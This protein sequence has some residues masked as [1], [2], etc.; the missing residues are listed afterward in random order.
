MALNKQVYDDIPHVARQRRKK[1]AYPHPYKASHPH[2]YWFIDGRQMDFALDGVKWWSIIVLDGYSRTMLAG[3][4]APVEASWVT[5]M[6]LYTACLRYGVPQHLICDSGGAFTSNDVT[7]VLQR[8]Q[9]APNPLLSTQG[10]SYKN[11]M[12]TV[13]RWIAPPPA[14]PERGV[15]VSSH[16][17]PQYPGACHAY[18]TG[19]SPHAPVFSH[20]G[21]AHGALANWC[22]AHLGDHH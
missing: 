13:E 10:E 15:I 5:L 3:A 21:S 11:L 18:L 22:R 4:V 19:D 9:I 14:V 8:L 16:T 12:V 7:A 17:A 2:Q 6:V 1:P 20:H